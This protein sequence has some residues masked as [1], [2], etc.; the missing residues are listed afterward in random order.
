MSRRT[1]E[2]DGTSAVQRVR[3]RYRVI[4]L[5]AA[6]ATAIGGVGIANREGADGST[7][8]TQSSGTDWAI[9][10]CG[11]YS[12]NGCAPMS[13]RVDLVRPRFSN[14]TTIDN[15]YFPVAHSVIQLGHVD[16]A[17]FRSETTRLGRTEAV[18]WEGKPVQTV[19]VQ[20]A[21]W[22]D[23]EIEEVAIDRYAQADDGSVWYFGED[24]YDYDE[25]SIVLTEGTWLAGR[26]GPPAMI[27]P[28][29]PRLGDVFRPENILG[30]V[31]EEVEVHEVGVTVEGPDGPIDDAIITREL[32]LDGSYSDKVFAPSIGEFRTENADELEAVALV[33]SGTEQPASRDV[34]AMITAAWGTLELIRLEEWDD[35]TRSVDRLTRH[36]RRVRT[37]APPLVVEPMTAS[38]RAL[39]RAIKAESADHAERATVAVAEI[40]IDLAARTTAAA[41]IEGERFHLHAQSARIAAA[42]GQNALTT[43]E[44]SALEWIRDRFADNITLANLA[45]IDARLA[46]IRT[47][48]DIGNL[49]AVAD[50]AARLAALVRVA[51]VR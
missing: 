33:V 11:T 20:Y 22:I 28:A 19:L 25:G 32:H 16:G 44:V 14:P 36:W 46:A 31:F 50:H 40:S 23:G 6:I 45:E 26:D 43:S 15:E 47:A 27:M 18:V 48:M 2:H 10:E 1:T 42:N 41:A 4:A 30:V 21:A 9:T 3:R 29:D 7:T 34:A 51:T 49:P 5:T 38:L 37:D 13:Q 12:G 8:R 24:V 17:P 39:R 35:A